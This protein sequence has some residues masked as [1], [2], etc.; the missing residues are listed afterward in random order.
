MRFEEQSARVAG[1]FDD[2]F[3]RM[4]RMYL[5]CSEAC[6]ASGDMQ[7]FQVTFGRATDN[8]RRWTRSDLY[9]PAQP[10]TIA[11]AVEIHHAHV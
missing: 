9:T 6:F 7:L 11:D 4:W 5:A 2:R 3:V 8:A 1:M 10:A